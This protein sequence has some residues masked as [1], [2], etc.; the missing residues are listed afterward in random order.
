MQRS[1]DTTDFIIGKGAARPLMP[2][3]RSPERGG[4]IRGRSQPAAVG[5]SNSGMHPTADTPLVI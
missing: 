2:G 5:R 1:A 4:P 3:V